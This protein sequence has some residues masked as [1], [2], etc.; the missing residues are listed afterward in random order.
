[1]TVGFGS[2]I[3]GSWWQVMASSR[4]ILSMRLGVENLASCLNYFVLFP[5][6]FMHYGCCGCLLEETNA[7][8]IGAS[9]TFLFLLFLYLITILKYMLLLHTLWYQI[10]VRM[11]IVHMGFIHWD[12]VSLAW[13]FSCFWEILLKRVRKHKEEKYNNFLL[14]SSLKQEI[15]KWNYLWGGSQ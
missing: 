14:W 3:S 2:K 10:C 7:A 13:N 1:M 15:V 9:M 12:L 5:V 6:N 4:E 11:L 8:K